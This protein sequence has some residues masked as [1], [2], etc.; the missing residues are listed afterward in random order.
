MLDHMVVRLGKYLRIVGYDAAW[1]L[2]LRTHELIQQA[3]ATGRTF[4][5][6][7]RHITEQFPPVR[8]L[9]L[10]SA[11]DPVEQ[12]NI[13]V[14][15][16]HLDT[17]GG[18]FSRC[19]RCNEPLAPLTDKAEA[20]DRVHPN[21]LARQDRFF[22]C[23]HCGTVFWHGSHVSN[24]CRKLGLEPPTSASAAKPPDRCR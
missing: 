13:L 24:T 11:T 20:R 7:N 3:N 9:I 17:R 1:D 22:R 12:F 2:G 4:V 23:P 6:R 5:T 14:R 19:V 18:L 10:L 21:V 16:R 15:E 8:D